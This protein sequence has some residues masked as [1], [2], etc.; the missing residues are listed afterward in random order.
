MIEFCSHSCRISYFGY[1]AE[2]NVGVV[3]VIRVISKEQERGT[4]T[5]SLKNIL[6][7]SVGLVVVT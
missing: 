3:V 6:I 2:M 1:V 7:S 5:V 4:R